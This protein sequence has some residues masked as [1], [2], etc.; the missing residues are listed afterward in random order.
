M[1]REPKNV[2]LTFTGRRPSEEE[3]AALSKFI[4]KKRDAQRIEHPLHRKWIMQ[5]FNITS[6]QLSGAI[7]AVGNK[8]TKVKEYLKA[9]YK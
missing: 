1:I 2:D 3:F 4:Q 8:S 6:Q 7:R 5:E 9:K